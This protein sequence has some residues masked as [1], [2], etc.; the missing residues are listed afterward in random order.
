MVMVP[1]GLNLY[2]SRT[3]LIKKAHR[4]IYSFMVPKNEKKTSQNRLYSLPITSFDV[5][6]V[7]KRRPKALAITIQAPMRREKK[8]KLKK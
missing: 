5:M 2:W 3:T 8:V 7:S 1:S 6:A 4:L